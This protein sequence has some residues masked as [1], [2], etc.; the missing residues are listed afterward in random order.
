LLLN[1]YDSAL[2]FLHKGDFL[3]NADIRTVQAIAILG[4]VFN[5]VGDS[6]L[7]NTLW[8]CAIRIAQ[9]LKMDDDRAHQDEPLHLTQMR[10]RLWWTLI[11]C[12]WIPIPYRAP[13]IQEGDFQ[14]ELPACLDDQE[15]ESAIVISE[16]RP[17]PVQYHIAMIKLA[18]LYHRFRCSLKLCAGQTTK[19]ASLVLKTDEALANII[20]DLPLHLQGGGQ[21]SDPRVT[22]QEI[23]DP[24]IPWQRT[25]LSLVLFYYRIV[26]N[27]VLQDQ[28]VQDPTAFARARAICLSSARGIISLATE[29]TGSLAR[30][31][32]W[33]NSFQSALGDITNNC[34]GNFAASFLCS[35]NFGR[36]STIPRQ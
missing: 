12:E 32:P 34:Q 9:S 19:T 1:W 6:K 21:S 4:I 31:R 20:E 33:Y 8:A 24:W 5:N 17:R 35:N 25:N 7:H 30:H 26:I 23:T 18:I 22:S 29:F 36:R 2:Y 14:V 27:R 16:G 10:C 15:L 3:R 11:L 28:W 13:C